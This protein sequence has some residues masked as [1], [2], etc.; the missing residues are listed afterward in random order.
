MP[1]RL[2]SASDGQTSGSKASDGRAGEGQAGGRANEYVRL[3][4][5]QPPEVLA[6]A[7]RS[8]AAIPARSR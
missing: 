1:G 4:F 5:T 6:A 2:L 7:V 3:A 8:L